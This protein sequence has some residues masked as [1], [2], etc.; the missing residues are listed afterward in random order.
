MSSFKFGKHKGKEVSRVVTEDRGYLDWYLEQPVN[1]KY[2]IQE[3]MFRGEIKAELERVPVVGKATP[4][5][6]T[7]DTIKQIFQAQII[8]KWFET[9]ELLTKIE[10]NTRGPNWEE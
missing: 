3:D 1:P 7:T 9:N 6:P 10:K 4:A 5:N 8:E 2:Q